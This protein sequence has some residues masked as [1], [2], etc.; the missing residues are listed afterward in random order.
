MNLSLARPKSFLGIQVNKTTFKRDIS[1]YI[2]FLH[3][4]Q[5][6]LVLLLRQLSEEAPDERV[7]VSSPVDGPESLIFGVSH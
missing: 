2:S 7:V 4:I 1:T 6:R 5:H 3:T